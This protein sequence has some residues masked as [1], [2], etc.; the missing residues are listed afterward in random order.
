MAST[1]ADLVGKNFERSVMIIIVNNV[2]VN[3][4]RYLNWQMLPSVRLAVK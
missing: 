4:L 2:K 1:V 3:A